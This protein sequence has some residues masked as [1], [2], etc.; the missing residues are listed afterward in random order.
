[1]AKAVFDPKAANIWTARIIPLV[2]IGIVGYATWVFIVLLCVDYLLKPTALSPAS[3]PGTAIALIAV[4]CILL[5]LIA[6]TYSRLLYIVTTDPGYV[7]RGQRWYAN[8]EL[9]KKS[10]PRTHPGNRE[11]RASRNANGT[12][13]LGN[14]HN[15]KYAYPDGPPIEEPDVPEEEITN[16]RSLYTKDAFTCEGDGRPVWCSTC[17]NFKPDSE[18]GGVISENSFKF[19]IQFVFWAA[20]YC[21]YNLTVMALFVAESK[22][23]WRS[24]WFIRLRHDALFLAIRPPEYHDDRESEPTQQ[25]L[26]SCSLHAFFYHLLCTSVVSY[27]YLP[28]WLRFPDQDDSLPQPSSPANSPRTFAILHSKPG[29][30]IWDLGYWLNLKSV[31]GETW[32]DWLLPIKYSPCCNHDRYG[33]Q[34]AMG[35]VVDRM[36]ESAGIHLAYDAGKPE[37]RRRKK[38]RTTHTTPSD[39][40]S[41]RRSRRK[42]RREKEVEMTEMERGDTTER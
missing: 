13:V 42:K 16:L 1:M 39:G 19:F 26:E 5:L 31:M 33:S 8:K 14:G 30:N 29:E 2:L 37:R 36:R 10:R 21:I 9:Q 15:G 25:S 7:P 28:T 22:K 20:I 35:P 23:N 32:Y 24:L 34:F 27:R 3:R 6:L 17:L 41:T 4:Y 40:T 18:V 38:R 12:A 11:S